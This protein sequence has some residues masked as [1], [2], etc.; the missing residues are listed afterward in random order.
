MHRSALTSHRRVEVTFDEC[1]KRNDV[2]TRLRLVCDGTPVVIESRQGRWDVADEGALR[3][4]LAVL[5]GLGAAGQA[6]DRALGVCS[7][8]NA[9]LIYPDE[10]KTLNKQLAALDNHLPRHFYRVDREQQIAITQACAHLNSEGAWRWL[11]WMLPKRLEPSLR[12]TSWIVP[13]WYGWERRGMYWEFDGSFARW[14][15]DEFWDRLADHPDERFSQLSIATNPKS[16]SAFLAAFAGSAHIEIRELVALN[17][18]TPADALE[19]LVRRHHGF[20]EPVTRVGLRVLQNPKVPPNLLSAVATAEVRRHDDF[21]DDDADFAYINWAVAHPGAPGR[22]LAE[23]ERDLTS[24]GRSQELILVT[25]AS[26]PK[27]SLRLLRRLAADA[28]HKVRATVACNHK[29]PPVLLTELGKDRNRRVRSAVAANPA[30]PPEALTTLSSDAVHRVRYAT[31]CNRSTP[32]R[33]LDLLTRDKASDIAAEAAANPSTSPDAATAAQQRLID[34]ADDLRGNAVCWREDTPADLLQRLSADPDLDVRFCVAA[35]TNTPH[36]A[37]AQLVNE[38]L[39]RDD[40]DLL[41][42]LLCNP[43]LPRPLRDQVWP[44]L[45]RL[46]KRTPRRF[47]IE[48]RKKRAAREHAERERL[49]TEVTERQS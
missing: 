1:G 33:V 23:V 46:H 30:T 9:C 49:A 44:A 43:S 37:F 15:D 34:C 5:S 45:R 22:L 16:A 14:L 36:E 12:R 11:L 47:T 31:A 48:A 29:A 8:L 21:L 35:H 18:S 10:A 6:I 26:H 20:R 28:S 25:I 27:A 40:Q 13:G 19:R 2:E 17:P 3:A 42:V 39:V 38:A 4:E 32:Q 41:D 24:G 7:A